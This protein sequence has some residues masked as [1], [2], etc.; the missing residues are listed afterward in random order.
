MGNPTVMTDFYL[1][2]PPVPIWNSQSQRKVL[3]AS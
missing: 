3:E 2:A 1:F